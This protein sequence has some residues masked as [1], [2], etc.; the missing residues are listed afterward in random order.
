MHLANSLS[1]EGLF[2]LSA[3]LAN[4]KEAIREA[5]L[6]ELESDELYKHHSSVVLLRGS[7]Y[8][9]G[10]AS[11]IPPSCKHRSEEGGS[12]AASGI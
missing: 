2:I 10:K 9:A 3:A 6:V 8:T 11:R 7:I 1:T 4:L 12:D 5:D